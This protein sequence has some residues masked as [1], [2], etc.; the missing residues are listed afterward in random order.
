MSAR[1]CK[2]ADTKSFE[3][4]E[5]MRV[6]ITSDPANAMPARSL[7]LYTPK[8]R[9]KLDELSWAVYYK[10]QARRKEKEKV[11]LEGARM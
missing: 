1:A 10:L 6:A 8:A 7:Y 3:E 4:L 11:A 5:T 2:L 9:K